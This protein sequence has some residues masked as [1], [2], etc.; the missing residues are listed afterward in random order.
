MDKVHLSGR[1]GKRFEYRVPEIPGKKFVGADLRVRPSMGPT[2]LGRPLHLRE[3]NF[4]RNTGEGDIIEDTHYISDDF[5]DGADYAISMG[6]GWGFFRLPFFFDPLNLLRTV[7]CLRH[8]LWITSLLHPRESAFSA[9]DLKTNHWDNDVE[10]V[11]LIACHVLNKDRWTSWAEEGLDRCHGILGYYD[12]AGPTAGDIDLFFDLAIGSNSP[13]GE[14]WLESARQRDQPGAIL[15]DNENQY[16][17][18]H[19][20]GE[21]YVCVDEPGNDGYYYYRTVDDL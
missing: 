17:Y 4:A 21:G 6:H 8:F 18:D 19:F 5:F 20:W 1:F 12:V 10:W 16:E 3:N 13:I 2:P 7:V 11:H 15:F 14:S 9:F